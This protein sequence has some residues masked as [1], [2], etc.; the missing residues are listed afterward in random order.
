MKCIGAR[1][2]G[3]SRARGLQSLHGARGHIC[4]VLVVEGNA[5]RAVRIQDQFEQSL[6]SR[7]IADLARRGFISFAVF[8]LSNTTCGCL[9]APR[10][11]DR[12][13]NRSSAFSTCTS[14][15]RRR[16][17]K[18]C[19]PDAPGLIS[20]IERARAADEAVDRAPAPPTIG[21]ERAVVGHPAA[22]GAEPCAGSQRMVVAAGAPAWRLR[23]L[24]RSR[25]C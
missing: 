18:N 3:A 7:M 19:R 2:Y 22:D 4:V 9:H 20:G 6:V 17:S 15:D 21:R 13:V 24:A 25:R 8:L 11:A 1:R 23:Y 16:G 10:R 12:V 14:L 5:V